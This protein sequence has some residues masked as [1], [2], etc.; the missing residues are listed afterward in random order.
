MRLIEIF[1]QTSLCHGFLLLKSQTVVMP[2]FTV[3]LRQM[4]GCKLAT[5]IQHFLFLEHY[6]QRGLPNY[7]VGK[8]GRE[9]DGVVDC[10]T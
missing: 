5:T 2:G 4:V 7:K 3:L 10:S 6:G 1:H 8:P 9:E